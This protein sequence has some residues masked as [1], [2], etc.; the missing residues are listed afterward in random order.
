M[1]LRGV[2]YLLGRL[3]LALTAAL[4]V[5]AVVA[6]F[7]D[8]D[9]TWVFA[10][11]AAVAG[12]GGVVLQR[13]FRQEPNFS[14]RRREAFVLVTGAWVMA[15][16]V[17]ALPYV[18]IH[19]P[20]FLIDALFESASGFTTTGASILSDIEAESPP[21][22]LWRSLTHWLGG[23]G[24]IVLGI[25][26]LPKLAVGGMELLGAEAP[27]PTAEKLT[28]RIAQTAKA[29]WGIY[30]LL[31][32]LEVAALIGLGMTPLDATNHAFA[33]MATGGFSTQNGSVA[34]YNSP[35]IEMV[36]T[37]FMVLAGANFA[38]HF[39]LL[40]GRPGH[41]LRDREFRFYLL[42]LGVA[43][44]LLSIDLLRH[45]DHMRLFDA[46]RYALFQAVAIV[47]TTG[48]ATAD[49]DAWPAFS[50]ALLFIMMFIGGCAGSTGGSVKVARVMIVLRKL[51]V[52]LKR[53]VR[54]HAVLPVRLGHMAVPEEIVTSVTTF[55]HLFLAT[56]AAGG[57][58][59][60]A[61]GMDM[62]SA[63]SA[64]AACLGNIGPGFGVVGPTQN[65]GALPE[66]AKIVLVALMI[67]GRL[68]LYTVLVLIFLRRRRS[69]GAALPE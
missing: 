67:I 64:S 42:I 39:R 68:E 60:A 65:Y 69:R 11:A 33:T 2:L 8:R 30:A 34:D 49:F 22:L 55:L 4:I 37:L 32:A 38:L 52:D 20:T 36:I 51:V 44:A 56:F 50:R 66:A 35:A 15:S 43:T 29:L 58:V 57:L 1:N 18:L 41:L 27:G 3:L 21:L 6:W 46:L 45:L 17:G 47:T 53:L 54:P 48:F 28:P 13:V 40:K 10:V 59:L 9:R 31:T 63:F 19:G 26:I 24:I 62:V 5:P 16:L 7:V 61:L 23:M 25:A 12:V 14:F